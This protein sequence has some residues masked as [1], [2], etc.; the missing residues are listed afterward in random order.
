MNGD[1]TKAFLLA[2]GQGTRLRPLTHH[3]PKCLAPIGGQPLLSIWLEFCE[4]LGVREALINTHHLPSQVRN[5]AAA[6]KTSLRIHLAQEETLLGSGG[7]IAAHRDF[8][9]DTSSFYIFYADNLVSTDLTSLQ[10]LHRRNPAVLTLGLFETP[11]PESCGIVTLGPGGLIASFEEKPAAPKSNLAFAGMLIASSALFDWLPAPGA[12]ADLGKD[13]LP[14]LV[15]KMWGEKLE[16]FLLDIGTPENYARALREWPAVL[17]A[18]AA[19][20]P[21]VQ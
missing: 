18:G 10:R 5:W 7:T 12:A 20:A 17:P 2:A 21:S 16:G 6:Q 11:R 1:I 4:R 3:T 9:G 8:V 19:A 14:E 13:V 15:G